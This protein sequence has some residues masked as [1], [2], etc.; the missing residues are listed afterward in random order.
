MTSGIGGLVPTPRTGLGDGGL[1]GRERELEQ[2]HSLLDQGA[3]LISVTG[4]AGVGKS[5]LMK[6]ALA[7][8]DHGRTVL[9]VRW[10]GS[11]S[12]TRSAR[13][14]TG[15][16]AEILTAL[17]AGGRRRRD[18]VVSGLGVMLRRSREVVL[19]L[20]DVDPVHRACMSLTQHLLNRLPKLRVLVTARC[21]LGLGP[22]HTVRLGPLDQ[23]DAGSH[24]ESSAVRLFLD[25][26]RTIRPGRRFDA[27]ELLLAREVCRRVDGLPLAIEQAAHQLRTLEL[28]QLANRLKAGQRW[29]SNPD[30]TLARQ[31]SLHHSLEAV[32]GDCD[33]AERTVWS[34]ASTFTGTFT[35]SSTAFLCT[36]GSVQP[37]DI[38]RCLARLTA[39]GVLT[40]IGDP[41][42]LQPMRYQMSSAVREFGQDRLARAGEADIAAERHLVHG[43]QIAQVAEHLW[44]CGSRR[45]AAHLLAEEHLNLMGALTRAARLPQQAQAALGIVTDLWFWWI[46]YG[47]ADE[48]RRHLLRLRA[49]CPPDAPVS[50]R[51]G[52]LG[53]WL[54][55]R[56]APETAAGLLQEA[57]PSAMLGNDSAAAGS[58]A[59]VQGLIS[60]DQGHVESATE[61]LADA[62]RTMPGHAFSGPSRSLA[63]ATLALVQA[64]SDP[65]KALRT[66][67]R[68]LTQSRIQ[69]DDWACFLA[70]YALVRIDCSRGRVSRAWRRAHRILADHRVGCPASQGISELRDLL[71]AIEAGRGS[72]A[73]IPP[74]LVTRAASRRYVTTSRAVQFGHGAPLTTRGGD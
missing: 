70:R 19:V 10:P 71:A 74:F 25:R 22:E 33:S 1:I 26:A 7:G 58:V 52:W 67:R 59:F 5:V 55:A 61:L 40:A 66:A 65:A 35:E 38:P 60:W 6:A 44:N 4:A 57:W 13:K 47:H 45:Q 39:Q 30:A 72:G 2:I 12:T 11:G 24:G 14:E 32:Y 41:G 21:A 29:L 43:R 18:A 68:A 50:T 53:A 48:G 56:T 34:R 15:P 20:D 37:R 62:A 64:H 27:A 69:G 3:S 16:I 73:P 8:A 54:L 9:V 51:E 31:A 17:A 23:G 28:D 63:L 49:A 36:G 46:A 42:G